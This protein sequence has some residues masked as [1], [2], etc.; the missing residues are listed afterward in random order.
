MIRLT[1]DDRGDLPGDGWN[2]PCGTCG[3][4]LVWG[5]CSG[6]HHGVFA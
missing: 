2:E 6:V 3:S 4:P 1:D 5:L